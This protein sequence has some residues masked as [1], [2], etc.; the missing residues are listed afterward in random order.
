M[1][2]SD[3]VATRPRERL[4]RYSSS[5]FVAIVIPGARRLEIAVDAAARR[6]LAESQPEIMKFRVSR[7]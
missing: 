6:G 2:L 5:L 1:I 4:S 3:D 7:A